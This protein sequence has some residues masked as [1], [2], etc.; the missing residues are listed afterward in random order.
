MQEVTVDASDIPED[1]REQEIW[2][3]WD[4]SADTPRRPHRKGDW[5]KSWS[6]PEN[7]LTFEEAHQA[8]QEHD[9]W[10]V[11]YVNSYD[12]DAHPTGLLVTIDIDGG[13]D[14]NDDIKDWVPELTP[15]DEN[16]IE[17][18]PS[19]EG[20]H[21]PL[22][23]YDVPEW[24]TDAHF[25]ADEHE[26]VDVLS[27]KF[28]TC[29]GDRIF[30]ATDQ[31][32]TPGREVDSWLAEAHKELQGE[33]PGPTSAETDEENHPDVDEDDIRDA[34]EHIDPDC[35]Y[36]E[37][38]NIGFALVN[39]FGAGNK[40]RRL[41]DEWSR[42]GS[43]YDGQAKRLIQKI[44]NDSQ[45]NGGVTIGTLIHRAKE[46]GWEP[47]WAEYQEPEQSH[48]VEPEPE[49]D[50]DSGGN[51]LDPNA[52]VTSAGYDPDE[53]EIDDLSKSD[54]AFAL[55]K[56]IKASPNHHFRVIRDNKEI[57]WYD[58]GV[59]RRRGEDRL[60]ELSHLAYR[61][62]DSSRLHT[63]VIHKMEASAERKVD[64]DELGAPD[65]TVAV[66]NG[67]LDL[68]ERKLTELEPEHLAVRRL[69]TEYNPEA[70]APR[71]EEFA[72]EVVSGDDVDK[73]QEYA[74]YCLWQHAQPFG[75][76]MFLLGP[77]DSGK[78]TFIKA[79][80]AVLGE[81]NVSNESLY[82][83]LSTRWGKA[84]LHGKI[85]NFNNEVTPNGLDS[86]EDFKKLTGGGDMNTAEFKG[87]DK[88]EFKATQKFVFSTN[89]MPTMEEAGEPFWNRV[90]FASFPNTIPESEQ[91]K[92][93]L[94][95]LEEESSGILNW[96]LEGLDR[97]LEQQEFSDERD[98]DEKRNLSAAFGSTV[99][100]FEYSCLTVTGNQDDIVHKDDMY[101]LFKSYGEHI[102]RGGDIPKQGM[103]TK[104]LKE[105]S[106]IDDG[107]SRKL[108]DGRGRDGVFKGVKV[109]AEPLHELG[110]QDLRH[111]YD[112]EER[113][114]NGQ[115]GL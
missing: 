108:T 111:S 45:E 97:L 90:L 79:I 3:N 67:L 34:L 24:W 11:G 62:H 95:K 39:H 41:F 80:K 7:W 20:L 110:H 51:P 113:R 28:C 30:G 104:S 5:T 40:A 31:L 29:T 105:S 115:E 76:A 89:Q 46:G 16:Y 43:S 56:E 17:R 73:L 4:A 96:M 36:A 10:G 57:Y 32:A 83:L 109:D 101:A 13:V 52:L 25:T 114:D 58:S 84:N 2:L 26:G 102:G 35:S 64:R 81:D 92:Q 112:A 53:A 61:M 88:F 99:E 12:N 8:A 14:Q 69:P 15:F 23:G 91:D 49:P 77:T 1:L 21:I 55:T 9:S 71:W 50:Q 87:Q 37:W 42:R 44:A 70:E 18:S 85:A 27:N 54:K 94:G 60:Q 74:G 103:F 106:G 72:G 38:R 107:Q 75:K 59:W 48:D 93:L 47:D 19:G 78:G 68:R 100:R 98:T 65:G 63:E 33:L 6:E 86:V 66:G 82:D 22:V